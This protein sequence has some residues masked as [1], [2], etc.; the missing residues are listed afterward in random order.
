MCDKNKQ[1]PYR[2][3]SYALY[4]RLETQL[5]ALMS[6][7]VSNVKQ[8]ANLNWRVVAVV[9]GHSIALSKLATCLPG[10]A[11]AES[12]VTRTRR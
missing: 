12:R 8:L 3:N 9:Q 1:T 4:E 11:E 7:A 6:D 2:G 5:D 10:D